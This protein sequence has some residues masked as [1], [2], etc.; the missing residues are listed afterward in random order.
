M[1]SAIDEEP[2]AYILDLLRYWA[3]E[4]PTHVLL[5]L[6]YLGERKKP[7]AKSEE[8]MREQMRGLGPMMGSARPMPAHLREMAEWAAE[9]EAKLKKSRTR[10][11]S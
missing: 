6:R 7:K 4:P 10:R 9:Q 8:Q 1:P 5:A 11:S 3:E 2:V